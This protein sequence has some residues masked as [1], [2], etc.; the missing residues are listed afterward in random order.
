MSEVIIVNDP[1]LRQKIQMAQEELMKRQS[2]CK[3]HEQVRYYLQQQCQTLQ[4]QLQQMPQHMSNYQS[5]SKQ[6]DQMIQESRDRE[7]LYRQAVIQLQLAQTQRDQLQQQLQMEYEQRQEAEQDAQGFQAQAKMQQAQRLAVEQQLARQ[8]QAY[9]QEL[10]QQSA[11]QNQQQEQWMNRVAECKA[12]T[13]KKDHEIHHLRSRIQELEDQLSIVI[14]NQADMVSKTPSEAD[15]AELQGQIKQLKQQ[16]AVLLDQINSSVPEN[17][18]REME[19]EMQ[20]MVKK[21]Q[22]LEQQLSE[23]TGRYDKTIQSQQQLQS[24]LIK[25]AQDMEQQAKYMRDLETEYQALRKKI[26]SCVDSKQLAALNQQQDELLKDRREM[27]QAMTNLATKHDKLTTKQQQLELEREKMQQIIKMYQQQLKEA[28]LMSSQYRQTLS[29]LS[30]TRDMLQAKRTELTLTAKELQ[31]LQ[32]RWQSAQKRIA[33]LEQKLTVSLSPQ[34]VDRLQKQLTMAQM[35]L[36]QRQAAVSKLEQALDIE[37]KQHEMFA[38]ETASLLQVLNRQQSELA[39]LQS[40]KQKSQHVSQELAQCKREAQQIKQLMLT[41]SSPSETVVPI[42]TP[43]PAPVTKPNTNL[44]NAESP[45][46][47]D[48]QNLLQA[49]MAMRAQLEQS[50]ALPDQLLANGLPVRNME[51]INQAIQRQS[52][53]LHQYE[54]QLEAI[55]AQ[56]IKRQLALVRM[57]KMGKISDHDFQLNLQQINQQGNQAEQQLLQQIMPLKA[58]QQAIMPHWQRIKTLPTEMASQVN[59]RLIT[60]LQ[61]SA[62]SH[63]N[64]ATTV[65][66]DLRKLADIKQQIA[67]DKQ[68][69]IKQY[70]DTSNQYRQFIEQEQLPIIQQLDQEVHSLSDSLPD[71]SQRVRTIAE[72]TAAKLNR[73]RRDTEA[74]AQLLTELQEKVSNIRTSAMMMTQGLKHSMHTGTNG[75]DTDYATLR[76]II[77]MQDAKI[78]Q[79]RSLLSQMKHPLSSAIIDQSSTYMMRPDSKVVTHP[80]S[81]MYMFDRNGKSTADVISPEEL[82]RHLTSNN[83]VIVGSYSVAVNPNYASAD[84][85]TKS[86]QQLQLL[87]QTLKHIFDSISQRSASEFTVRLT[88]VQLLM[89]R[90]RVDKLSENRTLA[91]DCNVDT[92]QARELVI[93]RVRTP[94]DVIAALSARYDLSDAPDELPGTM[95]QIANTNLYSTC[96]V[97]KIATSISDAKMYVVD[98]LFP[99]TED[100]TNMQTSVGI[101]L[102]RF[103]W[104]QYLA[105]VI[106]KSDTKIRLIFQALPGMSTTAARQLHTLF[107]EAYAFLQNIRGTGS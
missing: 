73:S 82:K 101:R 15:M 86:G 16:N 106:Q 21:N 70:L 6:L 38:K 57:Y 19:R 91:M 35:E 105:N 1:M 66:G 68:A 80:Q 56:T 4:K 88:A 44:P 45:N 55:R 23:L 52:Q 85:K 27:E 20:Q 50:A 29:E 43:I 59:D 90:L 40:V 10:K 94:D 107:D 104:M 95:G 64:S 98:E 2:E 102:L 62:T 14:R 79:Q 28:Q 36:Q 41:Q 103:N 97:V 12:M 13:Q 99:F 92:C 77:D 75:D 100:S 51:V 58:Q 26:E 61:N 33:E 54:L 32:N 18:R 63:D 74:S 67:M 48:F 46:S 72:Q 30:Q 3:A 42:P 93:E 9:Q 5:M 89:N 24:K 37:T 76:N 60:S 84:T 78:A 81:G 8:S 34:D 39:A 17:T 22:S 11:Y 87:K 31:E 49:T 47:L 69:D 25:S 83:D 53:Q 65:I 71:F 7:Q 96:L